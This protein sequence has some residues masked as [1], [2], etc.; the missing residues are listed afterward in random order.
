MEMIDTYITN[1]KKNIY[2]YIETSPILELCLALDRHLGL[3]VPKWC[4]NRREWTERAHGRQ[5]WRR[6]CRGKRQKRQGVMGMWKRM[7]T[8]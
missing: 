6:I 4:W 3:R 2:Q 8:N 1:H 7:I 5:R